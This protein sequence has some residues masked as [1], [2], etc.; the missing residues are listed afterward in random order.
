MGRQGTCRVVVEIPCTVSLWC[1]ITF[2]QL[3]GDVLQSGVV[4][5]RCGM[6]NVAQR[7]SGGGRGDQSAGRLGLGDVAALHHDVGAVGLQPRNCPLRLSIR[8]GPRG[9]N[10]PAAAR[11]RHRGGQEKPQSAHPAGD[12]VGPVG[13]KTG[14][15]AGGIT[16]G[17][18]SPRGTVSTSLPVCWAPLVARIAAVVSDIG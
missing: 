2:D 14:T 9:Q 15:R 13:A 11:R 1:P 12:D 18:R 5:D 10:D 6:Q 8:P 7:K 16:I 17:T 4:D 3:F